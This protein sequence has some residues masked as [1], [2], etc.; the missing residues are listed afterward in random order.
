[1]SKPNKQLVFT[2]H[3]QGGVSHVA[4]AY[5]NPLTI[6]FGAPPFLS[7]L[8]DTTSTDCNNAFEKEYLWRFIN[9]ENYNN[10]LK[11]ILN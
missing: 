4:N 6:T 8:V 9:S 7:Q 3:S 2:G 1:M 10:I 11:Q 5:R